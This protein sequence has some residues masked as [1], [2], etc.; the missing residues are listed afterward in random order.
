MVGVV[1]DRCQLLH[2]TPPQSAA[3]A[4][5]DECCTTGAGAVGTMNM[6]RRI[7][8]ILIRVRSSYSAAVMTAGLMSAALAASD[9]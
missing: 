1:D 4:S 2:Q 3:T 8:S 6:V 9:R 7:P 5:L